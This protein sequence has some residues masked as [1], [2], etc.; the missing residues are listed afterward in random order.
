MF[1]LT[2][3]KYIPLS[4]V[5]V[6]SYIDDKFS[7]RHI[8]LDSESNEKCFVVAFKTLPSDSTGVAHILE[9]TVLCGSK[10]YPVRDPFFMMTRRSLST[11]M[12][13]FTA[14]DFTAYPFSTLNDKDFSNLLS[15]YLDATF[16]PNLNELDF[17]QEGHRFDFIKDNKSQ[18]QIVLK[19]IVYNEMKGAMS[20]IS[21]QA[22]QGL[23]E[24]LFPNHTYGYNSGGDPQ[25]IPK[26]SYQNLLDF[27]K[28]HYH[29]SNAIFFTYGKIDIPSLQ[30]QI[31]HNVL[32]HFSPNA[33]K[34]EVKESKYFRKPKY[35]LKN[36][37]PLSDDENN[38]H[39]LVSWLLGTSL[40][41]VDKM[42][43]KLIES[44]L[45]ENS[46]SPLSKALEVTNLGSVPSDM[47]SFDTYKKQ[48]YFTAGL[49][50]VSANKE[51][52]VEELIIN[53]FKDL[54]KDGI[55]QD[56]IDASLHQ[57][58]IKLKK[59]SG[60]F[61]YG[62]QLLMS[63]MPYI[64]H[65][66][67]VV[68]SYDLETSLETLKNRINKKGYLEGRITEMFLNN[69]S[70][71]T[72]QLVPDKDF[73]E[74]QDNKIKEFLISKQKSLSDNEI[75][76]IN[77][78]NAELEIRQ[79]TKDNPDIL[80]KVTVS[81]IGNSKT[82]PKFETKNKD[83]INRFFYKA[84][85]NGI[86]YFQ[87]I[88]P[89]IEPTFDDLKYSSLFSDI[90][91]EVGIKNKG[92]EEIQKRQSST[93]GQISSNFSILRE[94]NKDI[95][96][97]AFKIGGYSLQS[98]LNKLKDLF[99]DT[100][101]YF[102]LDEKERINDIT[103][104]HISSFERNLVNSGHYFAMAN[105]D[106]Q[107]SKYGAISEYSNGISYLKNLKKL[108]LSDGNIDVE[109]LI[110]NFQSLK[111]KIVT[112]PIT[113]VLV[114]SGELHD[115]ENDH[116]ILENR[117]FFEIKKI[118]LNSDEV[119]WV[120]E[121]EVNFCAQSFKTVDYSHNDAPTLSVLGSVLRNGFLHTAIREKG[122]AYGAGAMQ[123]MNARTFK[124]FSYRDPNIEKTFEAFNNSVNWAL[125][126]ITKEKLEEGIL[127]VISSIDKPSSPANEALSDFNSNNNG[128]SQEMRKKFREDILSVTIDKL[129][130]VTKKYL[131]CEPSRSVLTSKKNKKTIENLNFKPKYI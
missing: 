12:N 82:Y 125:N 29:P 39:V 5:E 46:A 1:K 15:V 107:I 13:A 25:D 105:S 74:K 56:L 55:P 33:E 120:T 117:N 27:H 45:L 47:T 85:T 98:N 81:D 32:K 7:T 131:T 123:D 6:K 52:K 10:K 119:A 19:G 97:L 69:P 42:E 60:G 67:D 57:L 83:G 30:N 86:D 37:K 114:T 54:I 26:L 40:D 61:P 127:N 73:D 22:D 23:N 76:K 68:S 110:D 24:N 89:I 91:C 92:Y 59:I 94:K 113:E 63:S 116:S 100:L 95:F 21:S 44:I 79:N 104:M 88:F 118:N 28:K 16:F 49:E 64:L 130:Y 48:M 34:I 90:I 8:H 101:E 70:R 31:E 99:Y 3:S 11:F 36:Y 14:S 78:L 84:G 50:G 66:A 43:A 112:K 51:M 20:S 126:S 2:Q 35:A 4:K 80:P 41:P 93:V 65:D 103:K 109:N 96:N 122:G 58:E 102:R 17:M 121:T 62:L 124:F 53:V 18:E 75:K 108:K 129:S 111:R 77:K 72:F 106:A 115:V 71:L 9:H 38:Y 87:K 128:F